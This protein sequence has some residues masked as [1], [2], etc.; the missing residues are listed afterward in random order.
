MTLNPQVETDAPDQLPPNPIFRAEVVSTPTESGDTGKRH[1][2]QVSP[3]HTEQSFPA[4]VTETVRG[5]VGLPQEPNS[6]LCMMGQNLTLYVVGIIYE[7]EESVP[8]IQT[9]ERR[10]GHAD[11]DSHVTF[12]EDGTIHVEN[13]DGVS[14]DLQ[15]N[16]DIVLDSGNTRPITDITTSSDADGHV[17]SVDVSRADN[18]YVPDSS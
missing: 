2:V 7:S 11:S 12:R 9:G 18:I 15:P 4:I 6:V 3:E 10:I 14:I 5:D 17:T 1:A 16:G 8:T 13:H